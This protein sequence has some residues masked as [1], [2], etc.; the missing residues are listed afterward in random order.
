MS[1]ALAIVGLACRYPDASS[2]AELWEMVMAQRRAFRRIPSSRLRAEDYFSADPAAVDRLDGI[3]RSGLWL[4][5]GTRERLYAADFVGRYYFNQPPSLLRWALTQPLG[6]VMYT[7]L[8]PRREDFARVQD[9]M[10]QDGLM[11]RLQPLQERRGP[12]PRGRIVL[13][14]GP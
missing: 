9:L 2:P 11:P 4:D 10:V 12:V 14:H 6:R 7:P 8:T 3:A 13:V 1:E 5:Q